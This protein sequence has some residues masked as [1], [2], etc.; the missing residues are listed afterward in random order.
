MQIMDEIKAGIQ[1][2]F[3]TKNN[4]TLAISGSG[5][6]AMEAALVNVVEPGDVVLIAIHGVW[7]E[8]AADIAERIGTISLLCDNQNIK[9]ASNFNNFYLN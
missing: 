3:Q 2:A 7:G 1:Y 8:R 6:A 9:F 4:L 5:H